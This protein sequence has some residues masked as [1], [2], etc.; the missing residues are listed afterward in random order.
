MIETITPLQVSSTWSSWLTKI[1]ERLES[2]AL[3]G[4]TMCRLK[5]QYACLRDLMNDAALHSMHAQTSNRELFIF[6]RDRVVQFKLNG[7][8]L[9]SRAADWRGGARCNKRVRGHGG[10]PESPTFCRALA[11]TY[12][13]EACHIA[14]APPTS[15]QW[16]SCLSRIRAEPAQLQKIRHA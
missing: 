3:S 9:Q 14:P 5:S 10:R 2:P 12:N 15:A 6:R 1:V 8:Q 4:R 16:H 13:Q 11:T 7:N